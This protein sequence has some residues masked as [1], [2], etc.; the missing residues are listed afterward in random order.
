MPQ[1]QDLLLINAVI[2]ASLDEAEAR[3][4]SLT[5]AT[6]R[7]FALVETGERDFEVLKSAVLGTDEAAA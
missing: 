2:E 4:I 5:G 7:L 6:R 3:G 1:R